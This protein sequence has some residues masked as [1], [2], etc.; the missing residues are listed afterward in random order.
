GRISGT[1][2]A[3]LIVTTMQVA[4]QLANISQAWQLAAIGLLLIGSVVADNAVAEKL[5]ARAR[6]A[7]S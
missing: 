5:R 3:V 6:R 1:V 7:P 2:L 4:L